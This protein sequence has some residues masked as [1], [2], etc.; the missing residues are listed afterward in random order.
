MN[1]RSLFRLLGAVVSIAASI[2]CFTPAIASDRSLDQDARAALQALY[3]KT[4]AAR[5]LG[6]KA[7][8]I[9]VFPRIIKAGLIVGGQGGDGVMLKNGKTAGYYKTGGL[10]VGYQAGAQEYG[11]ALFFMS[12]SALQYLANTDGWEVGVGPSIVVVD[13]GTAKSLTTTTAKSDVYAFIFDQKGLMAG[14]GLQ[15]TKISQKD[16]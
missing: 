15:G 12:D 1:M 6:A 10:S 16:R 11:Y 5:A 2:T 14:M 13:A 4:P 8:G 7:T 3:A 9:L